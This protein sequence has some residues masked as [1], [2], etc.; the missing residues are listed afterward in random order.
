MY[1][2]FTLGV[3]FETIFEYRGN[4]NTGHRRTLWCIQVGEHRYV[5]VGRTQDDVALTVHWRVSCG[6]V[7]VCSTPTLQRT[8]G[9]YR[10]KNSRSSV[11]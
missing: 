3:P 4:D 7:Y 2:S 6:G 8:S 1:L 11:T 9:I 10:Q 5:C